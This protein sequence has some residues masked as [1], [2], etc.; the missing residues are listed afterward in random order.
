M[1]GYYLL[2][3]HNQHLPTSISYLMLKTQ[4]FGLSNEHLILI[5]ILPIYIALVIF[6]TAL[7][8]FY[9]SKYYKNLIRFLKIKR[10]L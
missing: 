6:G 2:L 10:N 7:L 4:G 9:L 3:N 5:A 1:V 8:G